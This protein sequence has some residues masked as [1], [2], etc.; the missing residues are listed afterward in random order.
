M[1]KKGRGVRSVNHVT[2]KQGWR[3]GRHTDCLALPG[4]G[5]W[6]PMTANSNLYRVAH[7]VGQESGP[8]LRAAARRQRGLFQGVLSVRGTGWLTPA[9]RD[10]KEKARRKS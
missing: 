8:R 1:K 2:V 10:P 9:R 5:P 7:S 3:L 4:K 6:N